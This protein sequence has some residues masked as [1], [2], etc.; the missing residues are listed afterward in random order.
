MAALSG[1]PPQGGQAVT[2]LR[3]QIQNVQNA[4]REQLRQVEREKP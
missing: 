1:S 4:E 3:D 2:G